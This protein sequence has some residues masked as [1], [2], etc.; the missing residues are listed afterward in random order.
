MVSFCPR[1][2]S[3]LAAREV[4]GRSLPACP[5][6][7]YIAFRDP[8]VV[9]VS[10]IV[11]AGGIW[12]VRRAIEPCVGEWALPGGYVDWD[13]HP[14][15]AAVRECCEEI[16][17]EVEVDR[18]V[19]VQ[20]AAFANGGVVVI[21]YTGRIVRGSP[22]AGP[23]VLEVAQFPLRELPALAFETH[24]ALLAQAATVWPP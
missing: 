21:G 7:E 16:G 19:G 13:E 8:K 24:R 15:Q 2:G 1:C 17:C 23:E 12:L 3:S 14:S 20:H 10:L 5:D 4:E 6:C 18:L 9:A 22:V 11:D